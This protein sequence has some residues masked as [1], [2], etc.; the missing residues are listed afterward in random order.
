[1]WDPPTPPHSS[2]AE[3]LKGSLGLLTVWIAEG[4]GA[5]GP[6]KCGAV[7]EGY[8]SDEGCLVPWRKGVGSS[9]L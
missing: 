9:P 3:L 6:A 8:M 2:G 1:M 4:R 7:G 5:V